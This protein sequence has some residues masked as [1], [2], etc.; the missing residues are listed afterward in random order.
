MDKSFYSSCHAG[1]NKYIINNT[2][3]KNHSTATGGRT[4]IRTAT[5]IVIDNIVWGNTAASSPQIKAL[6]LGTALATYNDVE[7]GYTGAGNLNS[8]P[9]FTDTLGFYLTDIIS[10]CIDAGDSSIIYNDVEDI[11]NPGFAQL[12]SLG[13][14]RNDM[15]AYG[16]QH[17]YYLA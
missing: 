16:G 15:G 4:Y 5:V 8:L 14:I 9:F 3:A 11:S 10:P 17:R 2:I 1:F 12:P 13:T 7:G 6:S